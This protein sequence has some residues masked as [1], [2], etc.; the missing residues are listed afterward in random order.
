LCPSAQEEDSDEE[1]SDEEEPAKPA[2]KKGAAP[3]KKVGY[4]VPCSSCLGS[5][6]AGCV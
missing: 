6:F 5:R 4:S 2:A 3:A 1:D